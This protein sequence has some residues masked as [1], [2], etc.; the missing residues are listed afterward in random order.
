MWTHCMYSINNDR[1]LYNCRYANPK[2]HPWI[3][4]VSSKCKKIVSKE[5]STFVKS[6]FKYCKKCE[7]M[8]KS[9]KSK[10]DRDY[11]SFAKFWFM[12]YKPLVS[13]VTI[14]NIFISFNNSITALEEETWRST[15]TWYWRNYLKSSLISD[16]IA[17]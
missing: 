6:C 8:P 11:V 13:L 10:C 14:I 2:P 1:P 3:Q 9:D 5:L 12:Q 4:K 15:D 7:I 16:L 17:C